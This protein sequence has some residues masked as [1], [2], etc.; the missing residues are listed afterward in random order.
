VKGE[1]QAVVLEGAEGQ[2]QLRAAFAHFVQS[3]TG[4][5]QWHE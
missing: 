3:K 4:Y 5:Q 1:Q 2:Q